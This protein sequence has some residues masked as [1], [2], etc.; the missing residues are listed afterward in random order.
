[1]NP[2][3]FIIGCPRSGTTLLRRMVDAHPEIAITPETHWIAKWFERRNGVSPEGLVAPELVPSLLA[4]KRFPRMGLDPADVRGLI[5]DDAPLPY[6]RFV[7]A[8]FDLYGK[9]QGKA[10]VGDKTPSYVRRI[11]TLHALWPGA[12][13]VH[14]IRDGR[15]VALSTLAREK[16]KLRAFRTWHEH[17]L[18]TVAVWWDSRVRLGREDGSAIGPGLY[19]EIRYES[20]VASPAEECARLCDFLRIPYEDAMLRFHEGRE[21]HDPGLNAKKA[22]RPVTAGLRDWRSQMPAKDVERFEAA[23]GSTLSGLEY[24]R[25]FDEPSESTRD[26]AAR[27]RATFVEA[28]RSR[29]SRVPE[30]WA[31]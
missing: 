7:T 9:Q 23:A 28:A 30:S 27:V 1:M 13:F 19:H 12:R 31:P 17:P 11:P 14:L 21:R 10:V 29:G 4:Y 2:Y 5:D 6:T 24:E 16:S 15:D 20:L 22:W 26:E 8:L 25:A 18:A 3:V